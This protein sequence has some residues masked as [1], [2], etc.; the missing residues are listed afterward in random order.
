VADR[1]SQVGRIGDCNPCIW[2]WRELL[3]GVMVDKGRCG[4]LGA[5]VKGG[6]GQWGATLRVPGALLENA[7][8]V[9]GDRVAESVAIG[10]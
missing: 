3:A 8:A 4:P 5:E 2:V 9:E 6:A 7:V 1:Y 10:C